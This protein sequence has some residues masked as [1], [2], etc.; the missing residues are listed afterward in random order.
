M[1]KQ[2]ASPPLDPYE[3]VPSLFTPPASESNCDEV[4]R[5]KS[6]DIAQEIQ[7]LLEVD[8]V[9]PALELLHEAIQCLESNDED[10][11]E[12]SRVYSRIIKA[13]C[14]PHITSLMNEDSDIY[15]SVLW[16][17]WTRVMDSGYTLQKEA[18]LAVV[19]RLLDLGHALLALRVM[20]TLPRSEWD[21]DCYRIAVLIHLSQR[22]LQTGEAEGLLLDYGQLSLEIDGEHRLMPEMKGVTEHDREQLW[23]LYQMA[24]SAD[25][26]WDRRKTLYELQREQYTDRLQKRHKR[27]SWHLRDWVAEHVL[28]EQ[29]PASRI[30][31][32]NIMIFN[33]ARHGQ[34]EYA[35]RVYRAMSD[36]VDDVTPPLLMHLCWTAFK[37]IDESK[38][39]QRRVW[40]TRAWSA[41]SRFM[42]SEYLH[43]E[44][45]ETPGFLH[46]LLLIT[47]HSPEQEARLTKAMSVYHLLDRLSLITLLADE[48]VLEPILC[49][50]L[51]E[52]HQASANSM[53]QIAFQLWQKKWA[54]DP[55]TPLSVLWGLALFCLSSGNS[56]HFGQLLEKLNEPSSVIVA[57]LMA[58]VQTFHDLFLCNE[59]DCYFQGYMF[60]TIQYTDRTIISSM[61]QY[62]LDPQR[63]T[64]INEP[65]ALHIVTAARQGLVQ[66][67]DLPQKDMYYSLKKSRA[68]LRHCLLTL[69]SVE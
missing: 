66:N 58:P 25:E 41:Y 7:P 5:R 51:C 62:G 38:A 48:R 33:A 3:G 55:S 15:D 53:G 37:G 30:Q 14:N 60:Q 8:K 42:C 18:H 31:E 69:Q 34:Y 64:N 16:K 46:D 36:S 27:M 26:E 20:Y 59:K 47:T 22:P 56:D 68:I 13:L 21:T 17:L 61:D 19:N 4:K 40:E 39:S 63:M 45:P 28:P 57:S 52:C 10:P 1:I 67:N 11:R 32:D 65:Q 29:A 49:T 6:L 43:P 50:L 23:M 35:W 2:D 9:Q 44:A 24:A 12:I 54:L